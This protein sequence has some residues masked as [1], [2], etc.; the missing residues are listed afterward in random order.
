[1][2]M[3]NL[4]QPPVP[5]L[6]QPKLTMPTATVFSDMWKDVGGDIYGGLSVSDGYSADAAF[7]TLF[8]PLGLGAG[9]GVEGVVGYEYAEGMGIRMV[10]WSIL[11]FAHTR[12]FKT[13]THSTQLDDDSFIWFVW[14]ELPTDYILSLSVY[15]PFFFSLLS[16]L[17]SSHSI[18]FLPVPH[19]QTFMILTQH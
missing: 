14:H 10:G 7:D 4:M 16:H 19:P 5:V 3:N 11:T 9:Y 1:M 12:G 6:H 18:T 2:N 8:E 17:L 13:L 15:P